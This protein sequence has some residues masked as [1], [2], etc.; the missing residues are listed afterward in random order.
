MDNSPDLERILRWEQAGGEWRVLDERDDEVTVSLTR[1]D[2][3]EE[4]DRL[5]SSAEDVR[6]YVSS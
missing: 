4:M 2:A 5:V 3:G 6:R 1:C